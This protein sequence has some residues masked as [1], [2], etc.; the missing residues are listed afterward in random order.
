MRLDSL[1]D[2]RQESLALLNEAVLPH[3]VCNE[4][5]KIGGEKD[6]LNN[7][8]IGGARRGDLESADKPV[9]NIL[10]EVLDVLHEPNLLL[11][12]VVVDVRQTVGCAEP[13]KTIV[14]IVRDGHR[15]RIRSLAALRHHH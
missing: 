1:H 14:R 4:T 8:R 3:L 2:I 7:R 13:R 11:G 15:A 12:R 6:L 5:D 10:I 9:K